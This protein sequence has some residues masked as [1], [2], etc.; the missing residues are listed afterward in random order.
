MKK[1]AVVAVTLLLTVLMISST[2]FA[3]E[4][5]DQYYEDVLAGFLETV[6]VPLSEEGEI[7]LGDTSRI[8]VSADEVT[9]AEEEVEAV[10]ENILYAI[11][12]GYGDT[13]NIPLLDDALVQTYSLEYLDVQVDT[14]EEFRQEIA[15]QLF[16]QKMKNA[17]M[18]VLSA[19][20]EILSYPEEGFMLAYSYVEKELQ[21][22]VE[23]FIAN[24]IEDAT[25][26]VVA[27]M[28]GYASPEDMISDETMYYMEDVLLI[29]RLAADYGITYTDEDVDELIQKQLEQNKLTEEYTVETIKE[30]NGEGWV[31][32]MGKLSVEY[33]KVMEELLNHIVIVEPEEGAETA[34]GDAAAADDNYGYTVLKSFTANTLD[35]GT[36]SQDDLADNNLTVMYVWSTTCG[37]CVD[38]MPELAEFAASLPENVTLITYCADGSIF[39]DTAEKI[40]KESGLDVV[41]VTDGDGD[42]EALNMELMYT[43]TTLILN[44]GGELMTDALIGAGDLT[45]RYTDAVEEA[46]AKIG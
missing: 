4:L 26:E 35:G 46:L 14:V 45:Q 16:D 43:P 44:G 15:S 17:A 19:D 5:G 31:Y 23:T 10:V 24:G 34:A 28:Y 18:R 7:R 40:L 21:Y 3:E 29:D 32:L 27:Q 1:R 22:S 13:S 2:A 9:V 37:Y 11:A 38:E 20:M 8:E 30:E 6:D 36:F 41:T 25:A 39:Q 33:G 42:F 12:E